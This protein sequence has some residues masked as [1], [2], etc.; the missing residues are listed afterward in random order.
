MIVYDSDS[1][2]LVRTPLEYFGNKQ[3]L[4]LLGKSYI[5]Y[6]LYTYVATCIA[7]LLMVEF[8]RLFSR[9]FIQQK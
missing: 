7:N 6:F 4:V 3:N 1:L 2:S 8:I 9:L 5:L